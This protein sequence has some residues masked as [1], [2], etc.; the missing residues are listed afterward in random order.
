QRDPRSGDLVHVEFQAVSME[1]S[2][3]S[4]V[5]VRFVGESP[6]AARFGGIL[7]HPKTEVRVAARAADLPE[8]IEV[9]LGV[10][11][12]FG[13]AIHVGDLPTSATYTVVDSPEDVL[14]MVEAP[15]QEAA[16]VEAAAEA[17][18]P[19]ETAAEAEAESAGQEEGESS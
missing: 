17:G 8:A 6:A 9:D 11:T 5:P 14:A 12:E 13:S 7:T 15:K 19:S 4:G 18:A 3:T 2:V 10:L 1:E 16:E